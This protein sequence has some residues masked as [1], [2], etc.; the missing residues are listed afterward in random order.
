MSRALRLCALA[1][2]M[3]IVALPVT[4]QQIG[5]V[6][7]EDRDA[8]GRPDPGEP[9][10]VGVTVE[11][12]GNDGAVDTLTL[13]DAAGVFSFTPGSGA[14][15]LRPADPPGFRAGVTRFDRFP[16]GPHPDVTHPF[17]EPRMGWLQYGLDHLRAGTLRYTAMGDSIATNFNF[18]ELGNFFGSFTYSE[19]LRDRLNQA[20]TGSAVTLDPAAVKG[21]HT[22][23]LLVDDGANLNNVF[24]VIGVQPQL[25]SISI[26]GNDLLGVDQDD[27][28]Q[29]QINT[30]LEEV[31]DSRQNL[32]EVLSSLL[33]RVPQVDVT[34]NTLYDNLTFDCYGGLA[35]STFHRQWIPIIDQML[36]DLAWGQVRRVTVN[37]VA[38]EFAVEDLNG[39]CSGFDDQICTAGADGIH[40]RQIGYDV[41]GE[42]LWE[43]A[44]GVILTGAPRE[45]LDYGYLRHV[46][47]LL[48]SV[49]ETR[50]GATVSDPAAALDDDDGGAF[51]SIALGAGGEEFRVAGFPDWYDEIEIVKVIAGVRYRT[52]GSFADQL[53]RIEASPSGAFRAPPGHAYT[54]TDWNFYT[55]IVG[56]GGPNAPAGRPDYPAARLLVTPDVAV[57]REVSATLTTNPEVDPGAGDYRWP[58]LTRAQ[59]ATTALRVE[60]TSVGA[61]PGVDPRV[62]L[63]AAWLDLYGWEKPRP[64]EVTGLRV[65]QAADGSLESYFDELAGAERYNL[66]SG[67]LATVS[68]AGYDHGLAAPAGPNCAASAEQASPGR[69]RIVTPAAALPGDDLYFLVTAHVDDV[70]SPA[71][72]GS[73][74]AEIDRSQ[75]VCD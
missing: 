41:I 47:R 42:K 2:L 71:G 25:V 15:V 6:V 44:S 27:P 73:G 57:A 39:I 21:E 75:S 40:P 65:E 61:D 26:I 1:A 12:L 36:R 34:L 62:E 7:F 31:L 19:R 43:A 38:A 52:S 3:A 4:A 30:A 20:V 50:N 10:I 63:E 8:D 13:T 48:P 69:L 22:D 53:Y 37:E 32:Q 18:C 60:A 23:D 67:R 11:L 51:A 72:S 46:R 33:D 5:G 56:A 74:G 59:L 17:G 45:D 54:P 28:D 35:T 16:R 49:W 68:Q 14:Y 66:Y 58:A 70:E 29:A 24:A 64:G 55:P 9:R